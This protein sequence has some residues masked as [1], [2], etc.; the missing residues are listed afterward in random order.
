MKSFVIVLLAFRYSVFKDALSI[1][2]LLYLAVK[3]EQA[4]GFPS[5]TCFFCE[6]ISA[7]APALASASRT[8][9]VQLKFS[10]SWHGMAWHA[11]VL[12]C[13]A[14]LRG[15]EPLRATVT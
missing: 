14:T 7:S 11:Y 12:G 10:T 1:S 8:P 13:V 5:K 9:M 6:L 3:V 2:P 15:A 4:F